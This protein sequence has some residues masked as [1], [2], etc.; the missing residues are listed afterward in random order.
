[1]GYPSLALVGLWVLVVIVSWLHSQGRALTRRQIG[2]IA[3]VGGLAL[4]DLG[5]DRPLALY[6]PPILIPMALA[7]WFAN[8]LRPGRT[9]AIVR[10]AQAVTGDYG[11]RRA[12]YARRLTA[13][14]SGLCALLAVE[15]TLLALLAPPP[16]WSL[17]TNGINHVILAAVFSLELAVRWCYLGPP[18]APVQMIRHM[19]TIDWHRITQ[20]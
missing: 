3:A 1:V 19:L 11:E 4:L 20:S 6:L 15:N 14:W 2:I 8:S 10:I 18:R 12:R 17:I 13:V 5:L 9:A 16:L 7:C